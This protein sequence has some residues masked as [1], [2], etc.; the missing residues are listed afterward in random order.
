MRN[1]DLRMCLE[2]RLYSPRFPF[3]ENNVTL[4]IAAANPFPVW[5]ESDLTRVSRDG[6]PGE[7]LVPRLTE[8]VRAVDED[9]IIQGLGGKVFLWN[10]KKCE[11]NLVL[12]TP[13]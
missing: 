10:N 4:S 8:I 12:G 13:S 9:L 7:P 6:V 11:Y 3:P 2:P 1:Y 5:R